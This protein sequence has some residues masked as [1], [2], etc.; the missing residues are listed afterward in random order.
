MRMKIG[1]PARAIG[2]AAAAAV[3]GAL[4][5]CASPGERAFA[6]VAVVGASLSAGFALDVEAGRPLG[7]A[8]VLECALT[9]RHEPVVSAADIFFFVRPLEAGAVMTEKAAAANPTL[10]VALDFLFWYG[11]GIVEAEGD[12]RARTEEGLRLLERFSCPVIV[13]DLPDMSEAIGTMLSAAQ[14]PAPETRAYLNR[15]IREWAAQRAAVVVPLSELVEK[16]RTGGEVRAGSA[17]YSGAASRALLQ[18]DRL[19][20]TIEGLACVAIAALDAFTGEGG[21]GYLDDPKAVAD[22]ARRG[23]G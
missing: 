6:R 16:L 3:V 7:L 9:A 15:R 14:V 12:R 20:P 17:V 11:Y 5:A 18:R 1:R 13:G 21:G 22:R 23:G 19:H 8:E 4:C 2:R 10:L